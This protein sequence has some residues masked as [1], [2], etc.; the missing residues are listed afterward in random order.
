[1]LVIFKLFYKYFNKENAFIKTLSKCSFTMYIIHLPIIGVIENIIK[2][3]H[4]IGGYYA[5][6]AIFVT[7]V[8]TILISLLV[9]L[10][11]NLAVEKS[12]L[13]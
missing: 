5:L 11:K 12:R 13:K 7:I 9:L 6:S 4:L 1:M 2:K 8:I 10:I 3:Y